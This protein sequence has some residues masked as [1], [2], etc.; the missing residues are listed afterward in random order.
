MI[1]MERTRDKIKQTVLILICTLLIVVVWN[2]L[3][4]HL[5]DLGFSK[6]TSTIWA[7]RRSDVKKLT[8]WPL[9]LDS[10][11][12]STYKIL[13][14]CNNIINEAIKVW[15]KELWNYYSYKQP[16][17]SADIHIRIRKDCS[18]L[19]ISVNPK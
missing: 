4:F 16:I 8:W 19:S 9:W 18:I 12:Y 7:V 14:N 3:H 2:I 10:Q 15:Y 6:I 13:R 5:S 17:E 1:N 11:R